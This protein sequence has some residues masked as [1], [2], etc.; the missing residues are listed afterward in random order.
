M[1]IKVFTLLALATICIE[2][3]AQDE[4]SA[5]T[6]LGIYAGVNFQNHNGTT[7]AGVKLKNSLVTRFNGGVN[8]NILIAPE[9]YIQPGLQ[10]I[11]KGTKGPVSYFD[12]ANTRQITRTINMNYLE[13]PVNVVFKPLLGTG[14]FM[15]GFGP[16]VGYCIGGKAKYSGTDPPADAQL[17]FQKTIPSND[18]NNLVYFKRMDVGANFFFGYELQSG[19][20]FVFNSQL[21]LININSETNTELAYQNTGFGITAGYRF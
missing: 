11:S 7:D 2:T 21:G 6:S 15:L 1:K 9:F 17:Q 8:L 16:Y 12:G 18:P 4:G 20:N 19:L 14:Y 3:K 10:F 5:K 13:V